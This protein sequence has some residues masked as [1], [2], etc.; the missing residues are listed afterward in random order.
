M[1]PCDRGASTPPAD[2]AFCCAFPSTAN[3]WVRSW[4][5]APAETH[6]LE[7]LGLGWLYGVVVL[8]LIRIFPVAP[9]GRPLAG[10]LCGPVPAALLLPADLDADERRVLWLLGALLVALGPA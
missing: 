5:H 4:V 1:R 6:R 8:G 10:L 3:R 7:L 9:R 2:R